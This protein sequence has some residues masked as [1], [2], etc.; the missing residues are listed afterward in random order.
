VVR[1]GLCCIFR[2][3]PIKFRRTTAKVLMSLPDRAARL[4]RLAELCRHNLRAL[5]AALEYCARNGIGDFRI[6]SQLFPLYTHP[7]AGYS[8]AELPEADVLA[9]LGEDCRRRAAALG[10]R[11]GFHPDQFN[12]L[13]SPDP[14]VVERTLAELAYQ[15]E[16]A[17]LLGSDVI[18]VH[19]GGGYGDKPAALKRLAGVIGRLSPPIRSRLT[20]ENDDRTY[21]PADLLPV[22]ESSGVPFVY[23]VH[24]HRVNP[25]GMNIEEVS[26]RAAATWGGREPLFHISSP[27]N[28]WEAPAPAKHADY[29]DPA[30]FPE[31]WKTMDLTVEVEAKAKELAVLDLRDSLISEGVECWGSGGKA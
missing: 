5:S 19:G 23:D 4:E 17:E 22:C 20:L 26:R 31:C 7:E 30:E 27:L 21:T 15:A 28:G 8:F 11:T 12:V 29:I 6:N 9:A 10:I 18:T 3:E 25:D 13:S 14:D 2:E 16:A 24:H 1:L